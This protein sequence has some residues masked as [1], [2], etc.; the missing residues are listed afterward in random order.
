[1]KEIGR[2]NFGS[3]FLIEYEGKKCALKQVKKANFNEKEWEVAQ[4]IEKNKFV[5]ELKLKFE[6]NDYVFII[7]EYA[8]S[9]SLTEITARKVPLNERNAIHILFQ[10]SMKFFVLCVILYF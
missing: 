3:V 9:K 10:I 8:D 6:I 2:G 5:I 4:K 7:M 1:V